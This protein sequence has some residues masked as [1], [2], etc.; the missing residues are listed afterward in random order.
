MFPAR[1]ANARITRTDTVVAAKKKAKKKRTAGSKT[2]EIE[3]EVE[4]VT[5]GLYRDS[6]NDCIIVV[7]RR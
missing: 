7:A 2:P 1:Y 3:S 5:E 4:E 6:D